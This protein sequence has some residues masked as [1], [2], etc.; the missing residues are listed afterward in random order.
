ME[1]YWWQRDDLYSQNNRL[2]FAGKDLWEMAAQ[3]GTPTFVYSAARVR[4]NLERLHQALTRWRV[5]FRIFYALKANRFPPLVSALKHWG[6]C[7]IDVCS[8]GELLLARQMGFLEEE[9]SYTGTSV[10]NSDLEVIQRH[11]RVH[12]NCDA[13][14][15]IRRLGERCPGRVIGIRINPQVGA[16]YHAELH[17]AGERATKFGIYPDRFLEAVQLAKKYDLQIKQLHFHF[18]SGY[19]TPQL[20]QLEQAL[21]RTHWFLDQ[22]PEIDTLDIGGGLG[23][24]V[25]EDR[26]P[27][28][29]DQWG[30]II[31]R[32][33]H[34][35][36]VM[37]HVEPGDY[38]VK[39]AGVLLVQVNTVEE[40]GG[41][42][43][44]GVNAGFNVQNL[45]V[46]YK[47]PFVVVPLKPNDAPFERVTIAG[48]INEAIDLFAEDVSLP[49]LA[50]EDYLA[51]LNVGG[52]GAASSSNHCMR[53]QFNEFW[54]GE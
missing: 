28:D 52:Y 22:C 3:V 15:T 31:V 5:P 2:Y 12:V 37:I 25:T 18:G 19:L 20:P 26:A 38:L 23:V 36:G 29:L 42:K 32:H 14:S 27:L 13:L 16:G 30:A 1:T 4:A 43:F 7:G 35:R 39:D 17:Y 33:A 51:L 48:N 40:K 54:L 6:L 34:A 53:G 47:T 21:E 49:A 10:S 11:P 41:T 46:Y 8:P 24:P 50:E 44:V 45:A 9:I